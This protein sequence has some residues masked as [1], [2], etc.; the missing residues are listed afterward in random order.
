MLATTTIKLG[1]IIHFKRVM[2]TK[3]FKNK[4]LFLD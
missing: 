2:E 4:C 3:K 1:N